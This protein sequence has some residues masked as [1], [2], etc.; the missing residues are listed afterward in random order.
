M[1]LVAR[2]HVVQ[3]PLHL[4]PGGNGFAAAYFLI[5]ARDR[6]VSGTGQLQKGGPMTGQRVALSM[7]FRLQIQ[8]G[9]AQV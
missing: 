3:E 1:I 5:A 2:L 9:F 4:R 6:K 8:T 7:G